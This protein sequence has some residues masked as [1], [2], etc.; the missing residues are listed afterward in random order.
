M[1]PFYSVPN[2]NM[3]FVTIDRVVEAVYRDYKFITKI[4]ASDVLEWA[5]EIYGVFAV[6]G[7][8]F[9]KVTGSSADTPD[10]SIT[11]YRGEL[12]ADFRRELKGGVRDADSKRVYRK[13]TNTF[14]PFHYARSESPRYT[15]SD[16]VYKIKGGYIFV[17]DETATLE[18]AYEAYPIDE[19]GFPLIPDKEKV[20]R[21][22]KE[23]IAEKIAFNLMAEGRINEKVYDRIEQRKL[24]AAGAAGTEL[25]RPDAEKMES[26]TW[27]RLRLLPKINQHEFS[28][29]FSGNQEDLRLGTV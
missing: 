19:R 18:L 16:K 6:P 9:H 3:D 15:N 27:A 25:I 8:F 24:F 5:G 22:V 14:T 7:M 17:E 12:P 2:T 28:F 29:S 1:N 10:I 4:N 11:N 13:S 26:W 21:Y 23:Y 20:I